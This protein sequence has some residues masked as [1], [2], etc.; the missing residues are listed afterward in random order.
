[1]RSRAPS[2]EL[3]AGPVVVERGGRL[4]HQHLDRPGPAVE[5]EG[6]ASE[7]RT[8]CLVFPEEGVHPRQQGETVRVAFQAA[9]GHVQIVEHDH[10]RRGVGDRREKRRDGVVHREAAAPVGLERLDVGQRVG[11]QRGER[12][13]AWPERG[14]GVPCRVRAPLERVADD[15]DPRPA[16]RRAARLPAP[17]P[18]RLHADLLRRRAGLGR[19]CAL[20][21]TGLADDRDQPPTA[22]AQLVD[23]TGEDVELRSPSD[24]HALLHHRR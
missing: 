24:E 6:P 11:N 1:V 4:G 17:P 21:H 16:R 8:G 5:G 10:G 23:G 3:L 18:R 22:R 7:P 12:T 15:L 19:E 13:S 20:A 2:V 9:V 14:Q